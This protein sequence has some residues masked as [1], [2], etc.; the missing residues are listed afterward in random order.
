MVNILLQIEI[1][2]HYT[3][4]ILQKNFKL[5][6]QILELQNKRSKQILEMIL[7]QFKIDLH[8]DCKNDI[9]DFLYLDESVII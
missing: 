9:L 2:N 7:N 8:D 6:Q 4:R 5:K 1:M 3:K